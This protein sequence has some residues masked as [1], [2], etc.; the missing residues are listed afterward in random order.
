MDDRHR[1]LSIQR[2]C[3]VHTST[4]P[5]RVLVEV[6]RL[7][8]HHLDGH[9]A[10]T[11]DVD[12][13]PI[14][15]SESNTWRHCSEGT[16]GPYCFLVTTSGAIQYGVPTMVDRFEFSLLICAQKPKSATDHAKNE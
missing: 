9:D 15:S 4:Y 10:Q 12:L 8:L 1:I 2:K 11:P 7:A 5:E 6:G 14:K 3:K 13:Q 16:L